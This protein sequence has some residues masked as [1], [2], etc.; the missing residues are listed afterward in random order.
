MTKALKIRRHKMLLRGCVIVVLTLSVAF[1][2]QLFYFYSPYATYIR[3]LT[4]F[5]RSASYIR[6]KYLLELLKE[7]L[8]CWIHPRLKKLFVPILLDLLEILCGY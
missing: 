6:A 7:F 2:A 1:V 8:P 4:E 5:R 3:R